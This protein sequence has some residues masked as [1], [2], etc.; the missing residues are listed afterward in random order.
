MKKWI[1]AALAAVI[2][3][4]M[5]FGFAAPALAVDSAS[6]AVVAGGEHVLTVPIACWSLITGTVL[7]LLV[8]LVTK[9]AAKPGLKILVNVVLSIVSG[10]VGSAVVS[11]GSA[12]ISWTGGTIGMLT[13]LASVVTYAHLW[14][15]LNVPQKIAP[16]TG[17]G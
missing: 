8:N 5:V 6:N 4:V 16:S 11:N 9:L 7:P 1:R 2:A 3:G 13:F 15:P 10:I 17:L 14:S 12:V